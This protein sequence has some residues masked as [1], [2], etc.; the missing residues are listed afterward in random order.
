MTGPPAAARPTAGL[1][2]TNHVGDAGVD[3][4]TGTVQAGGHGR[5]RPAATMSKP[6]PTRSV[7]TECTP[8]TVTT[9]R[10]PPPVLHLPAAFRSPGGGNGSEA[11]SAVSDKE[12]T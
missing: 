8:A 6:V 10:V 3:H 4:G 2:M 12:K 1:D 7:A 11:T 9:S 5:A